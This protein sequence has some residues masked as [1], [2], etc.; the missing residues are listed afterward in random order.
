MKQPRLGRLNN[1]APVH[2][3]TIIR[4]LLLAPL[5]GTILFLG[6]CENDMQLVKALTS[7][8]TVPSEKAIDIQL[9]YSDSG[10][11]RAM[12]TS[13]LLLRYED[14]KPRMEFPNG[15]YVVFYDSVMNIRSDIRANR[16]VSWL[17][18]SVMEAFGNVIVN[19]YFQQE[20]INTEH[21]IWNQNERR[22][23]G[24]VF[25]KITTPDKVLF[26]DEGFEADETLSRWTIRKP[27]GSFDVPDDE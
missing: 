21:M 12:L 16:A 19:N 7:L 9:I 8:D 15:I 23:Y 25:V 27:R 1:N 11:I 22:I 13:A 3:K 14:E 20:R 10:R 24:D 2:F 4:V 6:S 5:F 26:G 18:T 17:N